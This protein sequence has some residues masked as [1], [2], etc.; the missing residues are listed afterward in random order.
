MSGYITLVAYSLLIPAAA[1]WVTRLRQMDFAPDNLLLGGVV[2]TVVFGGFCWGILRRNNIVRILV[3]FISG[4][5]S[6][7]WFFA[8]AGLGQGVFS[9]Y[10]IFFIAFTAFLVGFFLMPEVRNEFRKNSR[11]NPEE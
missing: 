10:D 2:V 3:V 11:G 6:V 8:C 4:A 5:F 9:V 7:F 1:Y